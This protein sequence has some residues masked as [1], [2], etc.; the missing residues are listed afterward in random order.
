MLGKN[1]KKKE[2]E[3]QN[4]LQQLSQRL[5]AI[6][7]S[8]ATTQA[9]LDSVL[10]SLERDPA[11]EIAVAMG[12]F[13]EELREEIAKARDEVKEIHQLRESLREKFEKR[14]LRSA[15]LESFKDTMS[16]LTEDGT[17]ETLVYITVHVFITHG[18]GNSGMC[19][20]LSQVRTGWWMHHEQGTLMVSVAKNP[21]LETEKGREQFIQL[22]Q[23]YGLYAKY[24]P[25]LQYF[26]MYREPW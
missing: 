2:Q 9:K 21:F 15:H 4:E 20:E 13:S 5:H 16:L 23:P 26:Q 12:M 19:V 3:T 11:K 8:Q 10:D 6:E 7:E 18:A 14:K 24:W 1:K 17:P 25:K 22:L